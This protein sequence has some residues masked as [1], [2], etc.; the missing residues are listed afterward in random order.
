[1][2]TVKYGPNVVGIT[3]SV[4]GTTYDKCRTGGTFIRQRKYTKY[5]AHSTSK[6][7]IRQSIGLAS[8]QWTSLLTNAE[9]AQ[10]DANRG[11]FPNGY[12]YY[13]ATMSQL[14]SA[15]FTT[16]PTVPPDLKK[17]PGVPDIV[18]FWVN[19]S[20]RTISIKWTPPASFQ[21]GAR[22]RVWAKSVK[23]IYQRQLIGTGLA[24]DGFIIFTYAQVTAPGKIKIFPG[25]EYTIQMDVIN[26]D[27]AVSPMTIWKKQ[28][29]VPP[30]HFWDA[31]PWDA[32]MWG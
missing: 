31:L 1:M 7:L 17:S 27:G 3:G 8:K 25:I 11:I 13:L 20:L 9:R 16:F 14:A 28:S 2:P 22:I 29:L 4:Y 15:G 30:M 18:Y 10:W 6:K 26:P 5:E 19:L 24:V 21:P 32:Y 23:S 12:A